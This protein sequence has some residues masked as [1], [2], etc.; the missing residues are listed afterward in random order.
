MKKKI[1]FLAILLPIISAFILIFN[2]K[3]NADKE[4][5]D[6][7]ENG[8]ISIYSS[9]DYIKYF[10][11]AYKIKEDELLH[12]IMFKELSNED[13]IEFYKDKKKNNFNY[14]LIANGE[15]EKAS[16]NGS[17]TATRILFENYYYGFEF[18]KALELLE[19]RNISKNSHIIQ[20]LINNQN[21]FIDIQR[22]YKNISNKDATDYEKNI[23]KKF[24]IKYKFDYNQAYDLLKKDYNKNDLDLVYIKYL[25]LDKNSAEANKILK[26]LFKKN[27]PL[28]IDEY[29]KI[30]KICTPDKKLQEKIDK[31]S[32][33]ANISLFLNCLNNSSFSKLQ[34]LLSKL[35][36]ND[37]ATYA[38][39]NFYYIYKTNEEAYKKYME[40]LNK[41]IYI[42]DTLKKLVILSKK[43]HKEDELLKI[44]NFYEANYSIDIQKLRYEREKNELNK[45]R[46]ALEIWVIDL[47]TASSIL[48]KNSDSNYKTNFYT[49]IL[50]KYNSL[51]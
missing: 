38:I 29:V 4:Y 23:F 15:I 50:K 41:D 45:K 42:E 16:I 26:Y 34:I 48:L 24:I 19:K 17:E 40:C 51:Y 43:L 33:E 49:N 10:D 2:K 8:L 9:Y 37:R 44:T 22:I 1:F 39:A 21:E 30:N 11:K 31:Y 32:P 28:A 7:I 13:L 5:L 18:D 36:N 6:N 25:T 35:P 20:N 12:K 3:T 14:D 47:K 27:Y 46:I